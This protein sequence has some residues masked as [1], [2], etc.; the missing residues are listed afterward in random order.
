MAKVSP[1]NQTWVKPGEECWFYSHFLPP[2][3]FLM[4]FFGMPSTFVG[5]LNRIEKDGSVPLTGVRPSD[6]SIPNILTG[7]A[8]PGTEAELKRYISPITDR[9]PAAVFD[10]LQ[11]AGRRFNYGRWGAY[12]AGAEEYLSQAPELSRAVEFIRHRMQEE[13]RLKAACDEIGASSR[14]A[15]EKQRDAERELFSRL[16]LPE[17][18]AE[19]VSHTEPLV[20]RAAELQQDRELVAKLALTVQLDFVLWLLAHLELGIAEYLA[21]QTGRRRD[22]VSDHGELGLM[23]WLLPS[24]EGDCTETPFYCFLKGLRSRFGAAETPMSW[25]KLSQYVPVFEEVAALGNAPD[26]RLATMKEWRKNK[27]LPS[28]ERLEVFVMGYAGDPA[29]RRCLLALGSAAVA[30][31]RLYRYQVRLLSDGGFEDPEQFIA[32]L[33]RHYSE[34]RAKAFTAAR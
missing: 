26:N 6:S 17:H 22:W 14:S 33:Y 2:P 24:V 28:L 11:S 27:S 23:R 3:E 32:S 30:L 5:L 10:D 21:E 12:L 9:I 25:S 19:L 29:E 18:L 13:Q 8:K 4:Q 7:R 20:D 15:S 16:T 1:P 34:H 31:T